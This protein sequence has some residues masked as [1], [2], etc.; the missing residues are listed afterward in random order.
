MS[1]HG[2]HSSIQPE[3]SHCYNQVEVEVVKNSGKE[4][5]LFKCAHP[6]FLNYL[7]PEVKISEQAAIKETNNIKKASG[8]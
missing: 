7:A 3:L 5:M 4:Q 2:H 6:S 1:C 8:S